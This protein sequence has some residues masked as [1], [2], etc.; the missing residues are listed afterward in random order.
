MASHQEAKKTQE[1][2]PE[3]DHVAK[4]Q[5]FAMGCFSSNMLTATANEK[6]PKMR[7]TREWY[8]KMT[9]GMRAKGSQL[10]KLHNSSLQVQ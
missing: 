4:K 6:T 8:T 10:A 5:P 7:G 9:L 2:I 1:R 3:I